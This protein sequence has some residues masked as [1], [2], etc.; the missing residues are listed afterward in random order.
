[1]ARPSFRMGY[2]ASP[3]SRGSTVGLWGGRTVRWTPVLLFMGGGWAIMLD[4]VQNV[5]GLENEL[6]K[7]AGS[8]SRTPPG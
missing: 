7:A 4:P 8:R 3:T 2:C 1:M 6:K 5:A